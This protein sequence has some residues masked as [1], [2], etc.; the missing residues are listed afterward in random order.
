MKTASFAAPEPSGATDRRSWRDQRHVD[1][2][3]EAQV[4]C[5]QHDHTKMSESSVRATNTSMRTGVAIRPATG[6]LASTASALCRAL[7]SR[8]RDPYNFVGFKGPVDVIVD[9]PG[10]GLATALRPDPLAGR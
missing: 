5:P 2:P 9:M 1:G 6:L 8:S 10:L 7:G 3:V 4:N